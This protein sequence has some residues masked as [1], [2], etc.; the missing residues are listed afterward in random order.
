MAK[1]SLW[2][3]YPK[4]LLVPMALGVSTLLLIM[5]LSLPLMDAQTGILWARWKSS[6][7][8]WAGVVALWQSNE[9]LLALVLFF[10]S[11][12]FPLA[13]LAML[14]TIW[15]VRLA[16][17][18]RSGLLG[19]LEALG[20]WSML[21]VF[22]VAILIVL[23]KLG[24]LANVQP[25]SGVYVFTAAILASMLTTKYVDSLARRS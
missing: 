10:F 4:Q 12:V 24:P 21:D 16:E 2:E 8:V 20:K 3:H 7:S 25:R 17:E 13:K 15:Y 14:T 22:V 9:L 5:G 18:Q 1:Q 11:I 23:V 6:Y 19:W